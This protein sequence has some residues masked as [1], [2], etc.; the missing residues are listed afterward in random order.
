MTMRDVPFGK[1]RLIYLI[2]AV[3]LGLMAIFGVVMFTETARDTDAA[4]KAQR[5][6]DRLADAGLPAPE[7]RVIGDSLGR[8]GGLVCQDPSS[9]LI[10]ARYQSAISNGA[11]GPGSRPVIG[12]RDVAVAVELTIATYCPDRL[13]SYLN[14][15]RDMKF[16]DTTK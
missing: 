12:D 8:D 10:K 11:D 15:V 7:P 14:Q 5:L 9:P 3:L 2:S 16:D 13:G 6:H 1:R 4:A